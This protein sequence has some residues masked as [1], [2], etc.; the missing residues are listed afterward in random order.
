MVVTT[1]EKE[2]AMSIIRHE[3]SLNL[4]NSLNV[5]Q[6]KLMR[7]GLEED[8]VIVDRARSLILSYDYLRKHDD[9]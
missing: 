2:L 6:G 5:L 4:V 3:D 9:A 7:L 1:S 8:E